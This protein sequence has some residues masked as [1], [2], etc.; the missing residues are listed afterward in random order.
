MTAKL[1]WAF[2]LFITPLVGAPA[3]YN[4]HVV[5]TVFQTCGEHYRALITLDDGSTWS[6]EGFPENVSASDLEPFLNEK[7]Q[8]IIF[9]GPKLP[10]KYIL[11]T[12]HYPLQVLCTP[13]TKALLPK[14]AEINF[15][16]LKKWFGEPSFVMTIKL[17]DGAVFEYVN[18]L[19][20]KAFLE[21][22][23]VG[24]PI[25]ACSC[26]GPNQNHEYILTNVDLWFYNHN[27]LCKKC[28]DQGSQFED[29]GVLRLITPPSQN[30]KVEN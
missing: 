29:P 5:S 16:M 13:N 19:K 1:I 7:F 30:F 10:N 15:R 22:W 23:K 9:P 21:T 12:A 20:I 27:F 24:Q 3:Y 26:L 28:F 17:T 11:S 6:C 18:V 4:R 8:T 2:L 14:I 25:I